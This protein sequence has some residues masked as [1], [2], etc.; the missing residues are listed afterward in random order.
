MLD[1]KLPLTKTLEKLT[2]STPVGFAAENHAILHRIDA[3]D[4]RTLGAR[5]QVHRAVEHRHRAVGGAHGGQAG[6]LLDAQLLIRRRA[7][8]E[9]IHIP[10][11][12]FAVG[13][14]GNDD[15]VVD[16]DRPAAFLIVGNGIQAG[17]VEIPQQPR[18]PRHRL[19]L[20]RAAGRLQH[21]VAATIGGARGVGGSGHV[22]ARDL[23]QAADEF[24]TRLALGHIAAIEQDVAV[25]RQRGADALQRVAVLRHRAGA[26][27]GAAQ[28]QT[29]HVAAALGE[30]QPCYLPVAF[31]SSCI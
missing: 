20:H 2:R 6:H 3:A 23:G 14:V 13:I 15:I 16:D 28:V 27:R 17:H 21:P 30:P 25:L 29:A 24:R 4:H 8:D 10:A 31:V 9:E 1:S 12:E 22:R 18:K 11:A 26:Q 19:R 5:A 7:G